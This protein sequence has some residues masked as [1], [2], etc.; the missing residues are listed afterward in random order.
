[1][2][3]SETISGRIGTHH[4]R[5]ICALCSGETN[6]RM[7]AE[8]FSLIN[9][10]DDRTA[11]NALWVFTHFA[12]TDMAW[13]RPKRND[14]IDLVLTVGHEGKRRLLMTL[15]EHQTIGKDDIRL[16]YLDFCLSRIN[17]TEPCGIRALCL[18][19]A[20]AQ[21][22]FYPELLAELETEME[23][24]DSADLSP[25]LLSAR[26]NIRKRIAD[27]PLNSGNATY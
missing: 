5:Q 13:L 10:P 11:Y 17:S 8:L 6:D 1:M 12:P 23:L 4:I 24:M 7:K 18:K 26:K 2:S 20:F 19:Q 27:Y 15:L 3:I 22:R 14:L 16:D 21:C 25:A 9:A